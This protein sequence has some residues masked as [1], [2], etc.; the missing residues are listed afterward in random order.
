MLGVR[1]ARMGFETI[2]RKFDRLSARDRGKLL[3]EQLAIERVR[4]VVV[5]GTAL[6]EREAGEF[7]I[8]RVQG[9][10]GGGRGKPIREMMREVAFPSP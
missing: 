1:R 6:L 7:S 4:V 2:D 10:D 3:D 5:K 9:N 8:V